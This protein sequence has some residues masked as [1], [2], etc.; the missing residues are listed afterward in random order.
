MAMASV[1]CASEDS[2]PRLMAPVVKR[3]TI[4][5]TGSTS[6][7]G[8]DSRS[9]RSLSSPRSMLNEAFSWS[10]RRAKSR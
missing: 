4:S 3:F 8:M 5:A 2:D 7:T 10:T 6:D 1:S 9:L